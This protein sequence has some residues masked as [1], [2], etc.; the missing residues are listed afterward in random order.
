M[1]LVATGKDSGGIVGIGSQPTA[2]QR[3]SLLFQCGTD[4]AQETFE[5][6]RIT[7]AVGVKNKS[8]PDCK[9]QNR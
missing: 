8:T 5:V 2:L 4:T 3:W 7:S 6:L 1:W 9:K